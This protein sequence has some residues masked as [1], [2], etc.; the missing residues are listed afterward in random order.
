[1]AKK[2]RIIV[3]GIGGVGGY[4]GGLLAKKYQNSH[5]VEIDFVA[6]GGHLKQIQEN[7]LKVIAGNK[8]FIAIPNL[9]TDCPAEIGIADYII[10]CTKSYD[11]IAT[12]EQLKPCIDKNTI[13][14]PLLNG[15]DA[16]E[17]IKTILPGNIVLN[18]CVYIVSRLKEA[19]VIENMVIIQ[20][21]Y[22]GLEKTT[23]DKLIVLEKLFI[24]AGIEATLSENI[25][26]IIWEK[27]IYISPVATATSCFDNCLGEILADN[28]KRETLY[29]LID[30]IAEIAFAKEVITDNDI[31]L[32][33]RDK[34]KLFPYE[35]TSSMHSDYKNKKPYTEIETLTGYVVR[36]G[37]QMGIATPNFDKA[38]NAL[39]DKTKKC[40][41]Y[42]K[43]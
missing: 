17:I 30:E 6:R 31:I 4:F 13:V 20:K 36:E 3:A 2:I 15:V 24:A 28:T 8:T 32:K 14:L 38:Y 5:E 27:F 10:I 11:L 37:L 16:V 39:I 18:G 35:S 41:E 19:G 21:L 43:E 42:G 1:M 29:L 22:F 34:L 40:G 26:A 7:G 25:T 23:S 9:A 12:L 33:I